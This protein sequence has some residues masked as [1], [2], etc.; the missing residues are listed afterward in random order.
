MTI[1]PA[2]FKTARQLLG[3]SQDDVAC[4]GGLRTETVVY[5]EHETRFPDATV[6]ANIRMT[7][8]DAGVEFTN[9]GEPEVKLRKPSR[10]SVSGT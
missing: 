1:T 6:L 10:T 9:E 5:F 7:L 2:Q 3:W 8:E 4:A